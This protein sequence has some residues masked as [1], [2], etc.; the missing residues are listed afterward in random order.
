MAVDLQFRAP[1]VG[2]T[3]GSYKIA[4]LIGKGGMGTVYLGEHT[5]LGRQAAV[6]VL[7]PEMC[8]RADLVTRF[9]NEARAA[10]TVQHPGIVE[11]FDF[12]RRDDGHA[13]IVMEL[14]QGESLGARLKR[15]GALSE[16]QAVSFGRQLCGGLTAAHAKGI[17][18]R[19]LKPDNVFVVP[20]PIAI[21]G[22]RLKIL[23]FGIAKLAAE[24]PGAAMRTRTGALLGTPTYMSPEQC[25]GTGD[26]DHRSD[27][28][29]LGCILYTMICGRPPFV[30]DGM[31]EVLGKHIYEPVP[32]PRTLV[33]ISPALEGVILRALAKQ[34]NARYSSGEEL[35]A[36]LER[37]CP[38]GLHPAP[39]SA[40]TQGPPIQSEATRKQHRSWRLVAAGFGIVLVAAY[41][42]LWLAGVSSEPQPSELRSSESHPIDVGRAGHRL[43]AKPEGASSGETA[44]ESGAER[45][46]SKTAEPAAKAASPAI[47]DSE[48]RPDRRVRIDDPGGS[49]GQAPPAPATIALRI[50]SIPPDADV[51]RMPSREPVGKTPVQV[52]LLAADGEAK[53]SIERRGYRAETISLP[54]DRNGFR[55]VRLRARLPDRPP[56]A[57]AKPSR[58]VT[59][60]PFER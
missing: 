29:S 8:H 22:E 57:K 59:L 31:G 54:S 15:V 12:G 34:P 16:A 53:F 11:V 5:L 3:L 44:V 51:Y 45:A 33:P 21:D 17:I 19:D 43:A 36:A 26:I 55:E 39:P 24:Q 27:I 7:R 37:A 13:F 18:H 58:G 47:A 48:P 14:L 42:A 60:N 28:Y 41:L 25:R 40:A 46:D 52:T 9:F 20:D 30:S 10:S 38:P 1:M 6:K 23:D 50:T 32:L 56:K 4:R 49:A 2:E 35:A